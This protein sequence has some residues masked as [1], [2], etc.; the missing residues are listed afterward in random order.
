MAPASS[1]PTGWVQT[2]Y[3][4]QSGT[5][6]TVT[7]LLPRTVYGFEWNSPTVGWMYGYGFILFT[8]NGGLTWVDKAPVE[9]TTL[10]YPRVRAGVP[11]TV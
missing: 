4:M 7:V 2:S 9:V 5:A 11:T 8:D 6:T 10:K 3:T 1:F